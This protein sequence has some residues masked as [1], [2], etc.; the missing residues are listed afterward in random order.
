[1]TLEAAMRSNDAVFVISVAARLAGMHANTL[2]KYEREQLLSPARTD[3]NLRLYSSEDMA[4]LRQIKTLSEERG[5]N[6]AGIRL[7]LGVAEEVRRLQRDVAE[8][9]AIGSAL[10]EQQRAL[11]ARLDRVLEKL[12]FHTSI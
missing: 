1:M 7:A 9:Q 8:D 2:R 12:G 5:V 3:G 11:L 4:R 6:V 10:P